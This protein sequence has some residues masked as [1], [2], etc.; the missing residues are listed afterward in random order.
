MLE[1]VQGYREVASLSFLFPAFQVRSLL[2][3]SCFRAN[4]I[5]RL[6]EAGL[7]VEKEDKLEN[8]GVLRFFFTISTLI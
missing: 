2:A 1:K 6:E 4:M 7:R 3:Q 8:F 5:V